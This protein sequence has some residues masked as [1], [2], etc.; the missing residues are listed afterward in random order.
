MKVFTSDIRP[1]SLFPDLQIA[2]FIYG[3]N[4]WLF[5]YCL[6]LSDHRNLE[7][8]ARLRNALIQPFKNLLDSL[9]PYFL[10]MADTWSA[11]VEVC[12]AYRAALPPLLD[13]DTLETHLKRIQ[14]GYEAVLLRIDDLS[15]AGARTRDSLRAFD[16][17]ITHYLANAPIINRLT[18]CLDLDC[19]RNDTGADYLRNVISQIQPFDRDS[20]FIVS[21]KSAVSDAIKSLPVTLVK[22]RALEVVDRTSVSDDIGFTRSMVTIWVGKDKRRANMVKTYDKEIHEGNRY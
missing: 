6:C 3:S 14:R 2:Y 12:D 15:L 17:S 18:R 10:R 4:H 21:M 7:A 9:E 20:E 5:S 13:V 1:A 8:D 11:F 19:Y 22:M 16:D